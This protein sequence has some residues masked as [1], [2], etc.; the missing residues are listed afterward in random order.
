MTS[1]KALKE[2]Q[3]A[4]ISLESLGINFANY[5]NY[6]ELY[7]NLKSKNLLWLMHYVKGIR[8]TDVRCSHA[9]KDTNTVFLGN[10]FNPM[11]KQQLVSFIEKE[12]FK[13]EYEGKP[14]ADPHA[15]FK[16]ESKV[17][18]GKWRRSYAYCR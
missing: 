4:N 17:M 12:M 11:S 9:F 7:Y 2:D 8:K 1:I 6:L 3:I 16:L 15:D 14:Q 13:L 5:G 10:I 18:T